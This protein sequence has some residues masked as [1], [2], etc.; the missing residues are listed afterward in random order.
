MK[1]S[2]EYN[3]NG[4]RWS[5]VAA[6]ISCFIVGLLI[7]VLLSNQESKVKKTKEV[8]LANNFLQQEKDTENMDENKTA[9]DSIEVDS[10]ATYEGTGFTSEDLTIWDDMKPE[11]DELQNN[12]QG[13]VS[14]DDE[15]H[16][17]QTSIIYEDGSVEWLTINPYLTKNKYQNTG[18]VYLAPI[19]KYYENSERIS[20]AGVEIG[21][22]QGFVDFNDIRKAGVSFVMIRLGYRGYESGKLVLDDYFIN[23]MKGAKDAGLQIGVYFYSQAKTIEEAEEEAEFVIEYLKDYEVSYPIVFQM[24]EME[25][26]KSRTDD[27]TKSERTKIITTFLN[28]IKEKG[29]IP[30]IY[31]NKQWLLKMCELQLLIDFDIW[32]D[33]EGDV[34]DYPYKFSIWKYSG[35]ENIKGISGNAKMLI[36]FLDYSIK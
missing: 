32:L 27:L 35:K 5:V 18:L 4:I 28:K 11:E 19:M 16:V 29:Y 10:N 20:Y 15:E 31:A 7:I 8:P 1:L 21:K 36:S 12:L 6:G 14:K 26:E 17:N 9:I 25:D 24:G 13:N 3:E 34:P 23:N 2:D 22:E 30:M 33:Q